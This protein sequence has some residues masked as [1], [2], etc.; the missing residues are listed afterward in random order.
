MLI[1][2]NIN[3]SEFYLILYKI[4][5]QRMEVLTRIPLGSGNLKGSFGFGK[6][7]DYYYSVPKGTIHVSL[8]SSDVSRDTFNIGKGNGKVTI[9]W[10]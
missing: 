6:K 1:L 10:S 8:D 7:E 2:I 9:S 4:L 5:K 3:S